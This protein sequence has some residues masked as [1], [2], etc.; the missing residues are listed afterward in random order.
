[1]GVFP[2]S[3]SSILVIN[4]LLHIVELCPTDD[5]EEQP[6]TIY[7]GQSEYIF[8]CLCTLKLLKCGIPHIL[9]DW[10]MGLLSHTENAVRWLALYTHESHTYDSYCVHTWMPLC[11]YSTAAFYSGVT[12]ASCS[13]PDH[14]LIPSSSKHSPTSSYISN[15]HLLK[16]PLVLVCL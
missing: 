6:S 1:M 4:S 7:C 11:S 5:L 9:G 15:F 2:H 3:S 14:K 10:E 8:I 12:S 16:C 13:S